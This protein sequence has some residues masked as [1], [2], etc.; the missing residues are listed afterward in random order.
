[1]KKFNFLNTCLIIILF[2]CQS[3]PQFLSEVCYASNDTLF[4]AGWDVFSLYKST[5]AGENWFPMI[6]GQNAD[7]LALEFIS[8]LSGFTAISA[9]IWWTTDGG[10]LWDFVT[11]GNPYAVLD[12]SFYNSQNALAVG[13]VGKI[14]RSTDIGQSWQLLSSGTNKPLLSISFVNQSTAIAV[15][16]E[17]SGDDGIILRTSNSGTSWESQSSPTQKTFRSISFA[18]EN[19]VFAVGYYGAIVK[20]TD[21]GITWS[22]Q[23]SLTSHNLNSCYFVN[24][25]IGFAVGGSGIILRT[26]DS[27]QNWEL[28]NSTTSQSL[29]SIKMQNEL[30][31]VVVGS[32]IILR[33]TDRG[34]SWI[35]KQVVTNLALDKN[36]YITNYKLTQ[37]YPNPFNP[38]TTITFTI[39]DL[40]FTTLKV[41]D[42]LG[43]EIA[44]LVNER[45][46]NY[47][48]TKKMVLMK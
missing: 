29:T 39:S 3:K 7:L 40:R 18:G 20:S 2:T 17:F 22:L 6:F 35:Q 24:P 37:N 32:G 47:I 43:S 11:T 4:A 15:G 44:T 9:N 19:T 21:S 30:I 48:E 42:V 13:V 28:M 23:D 33:T 41:Y 25:N 34:N 26:T 5:N 45:A 16:G 8:P 46:G 12:I 1:M 27:G 10:N 14:I 38:S 31:G 36:N